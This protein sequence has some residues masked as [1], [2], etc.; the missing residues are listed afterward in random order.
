M[1]MTVVIVAGVLLCFSTT[2]GQSEAEEPERKI[3]L[4]EATCSLYNEV[5]AAEDGRSD[6][7]YVWAHGYWTGHR[8]VTEKNAKEPLSW[9]NLEVFAEKLNAVCSAMPDKLWAS[10]IREVQ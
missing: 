6:V 7:L 9:S 5:V 2:M 10:A 8:G 4:T 1:K 3:D